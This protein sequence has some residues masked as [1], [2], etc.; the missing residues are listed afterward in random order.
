MIASA[1]KSDSPV[2]QSLRSGA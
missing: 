2:N 1:Y